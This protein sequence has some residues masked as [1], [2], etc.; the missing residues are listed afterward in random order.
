MLLVITLSVLLGLIPAF[1][2]RYTGHDFLTFWAIG[3]IL[4]AFTVAYTIFM[5]RDGA[6]DAPG[7]A[8][9][10]TALG[11]VIFVVWFLVAQRISPPVS[12]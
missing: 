6:R 8:W 4:F 9:K 3:T 2:A 10:S 12:L 11:V 7:T 1:I 5:S